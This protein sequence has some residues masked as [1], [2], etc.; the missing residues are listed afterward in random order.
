MIKFFEFEMTSRVRRSVYC[1][2]VSAVVSV[3][4][5]VCFL[6]FGFSQEWNSF[7]SDIR[8]ELIKDHLEFRRG[9]F[10]RLNV[11]YVRRHHVECGKTKTK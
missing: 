8:M 10:N 3:R 2:M 6:F 1:I 9:G 7:N 5:E 4:V 11:F